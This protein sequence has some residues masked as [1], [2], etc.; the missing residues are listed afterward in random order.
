MLKNKNQGIFYIY[1]ILFTITSFVLLVSYFL[2]R[3]KLLPDK[4]ISVVYEDIY[5]SKYDLIDP[6]GLV[7]GRSVWWISDDERNILVP[8]SQAVLLKIRPIKIKSDDFESQNKVESKKINDRVSSIMKNI[9]FKINVKNSSKS[10][11][12]EEFYDYVQAFELNDIKCV[13]TS[14]PDVSKGMNEPQFYSIFEFSCFDNAQLQKEYLFQSPFLK[15]LGYKE[16]VIYDVQ[17]NGDKASMGVRGRRSGG[18]AFMYKDSEGWELITA[19]N[20]YPTCEEQEKKSI[21][22][23]FSFD[24][25]DSNGKLKKGNFLID[26]KNIR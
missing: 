23:E 18:R 22:E 5:K 2:L 9:G 21:P 14:S 25:V 26:T 1:L 7:K 20:G 11:E 12:D 3:S 10:I 16:S 19:G 24:C 17:I 8:T 4:M 15:T 6:P 13:A